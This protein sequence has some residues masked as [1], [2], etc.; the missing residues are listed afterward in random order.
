[1]GNVIGT[2][3]AK[4]IAAATALAGT[5]DM[6]AAIGL[7]LF[8]GGE[9]AKMLRYVA[10]GPFP[11]AKDWGA[12]GAMLGLVVHFALMAIMAA[13]FVF[14]ADRIAAFKARPLL[15]GAVYGLVTWA[16]M[17]LVVVPL[18]FGTMP[19]VTGIA[20]QLFCHVVLVGVPIA[21]LA[22]R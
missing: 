13:G 2:S 5:L 20:T 8:Y 6:A 17:N 15:W 19:S 18:R 10:S 12:G 14:A 11:G 4:R 9:V 3:A 1:M 21:Y 22:R 7:T 16:V